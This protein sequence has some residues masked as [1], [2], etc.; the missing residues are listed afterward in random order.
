M[1]DEK[2]S[3]ERDPKV[4]DVADSDMELNDEDLTRVAGGM[5]PSD[6]GGAGVKSKTIK[7]LDTPKP[8]YDTD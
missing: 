2:K 3:E 6:G 7:G 5:M 1:S 8:T 4:V